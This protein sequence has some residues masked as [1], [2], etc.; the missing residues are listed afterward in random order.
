MTSSTE[1]LLR[2]T[3]KAQQIEDLECELN[4]A[5]QEAD[6]WKDLY[7]RLAD[8]LLEGERVTRTDTSPQFE[9]ELALNEK[10]S[11]AQDLLVR[12]HHDYGPTNI[13]RSPG[14]PLNGLRVR[15]WDKIARINNLI[16]SGAQPENESLRDSFTDL[17]CYS[18]IAL[19]VLDGDWPDE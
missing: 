1:R 19:M 15:I 6:Y 11:E 3:T 14:G 18:I 5:H 13:S 16:D 7:I 8:S 17:A 12:K 2:V 4:E 9:F 10:F